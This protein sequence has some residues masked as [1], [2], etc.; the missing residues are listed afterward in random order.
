M[1]DLTGKLER[2]A[3]GKR[4]DDLNKNFAHKLN[5]LN[6]WP[7]AVKQ[8]TLLLQLATSRLE[9]KDYDL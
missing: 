4:S 8:V 1:L 7:F 2:L 3:R 5:S 6:P 9:L